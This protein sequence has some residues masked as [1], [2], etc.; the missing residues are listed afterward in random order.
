[1]V[2]NYLILLVYKLI[3][4]LTE[5]KMYKITKT[6]YGKKLSFS[7]YIKLD[8]M[9][10][11]YE[12]SEQMLSHSNGK[13][14]IFVDMR[15]LHALPQDS[16]SVYK[17][18]QKLYKSKGLTRAAVILNSAITTMQFINAAKETGVHECSRYIDATTVQDWEKQGLD[19]IV[20]GVEPH[21]TKSQKKSI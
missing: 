17:K 21:T 20:K 8:E 3:Y 6:H 18:G 13:L 2:R 7:G 11:W 16:K 5:V 14:G 15:D 4:H 10:K 19:W 1:M 12:E 9:Q